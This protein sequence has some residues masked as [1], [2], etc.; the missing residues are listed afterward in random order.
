[1]DRRIHMGE[2]LSVNALMMALGED[3]I[4]RKPYLDP[5]RHS[6]C[7]FNWDDAMKPAAEISRR[8]WL[9]LTR[10]RSGEVRAQH[11]RVAGRTADRETR[12]RS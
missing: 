7:Q 5:P 11:G 10:Q 6:E 4:L 3:D 12:P 1:M 9:L 8:P 2:R